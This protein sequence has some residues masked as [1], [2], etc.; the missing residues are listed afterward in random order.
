MPAVEGTGQLGDR[1]AFPGDIGTFQI[2]GA[3]QRGGADL[4]VLAAVVFP[5]YPGLC[6]PVQST[7]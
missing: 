5:L 6:R 2:T 3:G 7:H 1:G 4:T